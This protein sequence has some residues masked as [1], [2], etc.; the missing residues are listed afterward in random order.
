[1]VALAMPPPSHIDCRPNW[2]SPARMRWTIRGHQ[3]SPGSAQRMAQ[4]HGTAYG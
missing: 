2:M 4:R 3:P 1:M